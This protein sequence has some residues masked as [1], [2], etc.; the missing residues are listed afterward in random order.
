MNDSVNIKS[1]NVL[2][3]WT[4]NTKYD[5]NHK[6]Q[7]TLVVLDIYLHAVKYIKQLLK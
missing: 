3:S 7:L 5:F 4:Y 2:S 1:I 6:N